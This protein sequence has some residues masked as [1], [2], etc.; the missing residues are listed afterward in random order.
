MTIY[1]IILNYKK[2]DITLKCIDSLK[3]CILPTHFNHQILVIDNDSG[4]GIE[5]ALSNGYPDISFL[6]TGANLGYTGGNNVGI[7]WILDKYQPSP[8]EPNQDNKQTDDC[9]LI[10]NNDT[11]FHQNFLS[12]LI[13]GFAKHPK[14]GILSP[15]IYFAP[16]TFPKNIKDENDKDYTVQPQEQVIWYAGGKFDW[17]NVLGAHIGVDQVDH[18]QCNREQQVDYASGCAMVIPVKVMQTIKGFDPKFFMYYED[19]DLNMRIKKLGY[20]IWYIPQS[21]MW[22][23]NASSSGVG[24]PLQDYFTT[25]NRLLFAFKHASLRT[26][27]AVLREAFRFRSN[28]NKWQAVKDFLT[29]NFEKGSFEIK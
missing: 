1:S 6:Q 9:I 25:R 8:L 19:V 18:G 12:E 5:R 16:E 10:L 29:L 23:Y 15:K 4:D 21:I 17:D 27:I 24:S 26:K 20:E 13:S 7:Q 11:Y 22:H 14:A 2:K 3:K 28:K